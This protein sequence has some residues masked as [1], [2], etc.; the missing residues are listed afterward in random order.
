MAEKFDIGYQKLNIDNCFK[1]HYVVPDYQREYVW[2][3]RQVEQM[4]SDIISAYES[5]SEKPYFMGMTVVYSSPKVFELVDGQQR[6]TTFFITLCVLINIY[7]EI[8]DEA[9]TFKSRIYSPVMDED[10]DE[11]DDFALKLQY[12]ESSECL[13]NI[14]HGSIP[15]EDSRQNLGQSD[16]RLYDAYET[17]FQKLKEEYPTL[18]ELKKF[19][20]YLFKKVEIV[21]IETSDISD[22]L[23][24]F[25]TINQRGVGLNSMDLLKN[26]I[27][28]QVS[29]EDFAKL[30]EQWKA[31]IDKIYQANEKPLRFLRYFITATYD[32]SDETGIIKGILPE[33]RIY[34]WLMDN[35][36]KCGYKK[37]P[38]DFVNSLADGV[39]RFVDYLSP[40]LVEKGNEYLL[41]IPRIA[42][43]SYKSHIVLLMAAN[44]MEMEAFSRFKQIL[45][46]VLYYSTINKIKGNETEKLFAG[47][48]PKI[49]KIRTNDELTTFVTDEIIPQVNSWKE[50]RNYKRNFEMLS[51]NNTQQYRIRYV[52]TRITKY[53]DDTRVGGNNAANIS[54]YYDKKNQI[55]H[56][57]PQK[58]NDLDSYGVSE[59][60]FTDVVNMLGNLTLLEKSFNSSINNASYS[61]KCKVYPGSVFYLTKS[62]PKLEDVGKETASTKMNKKLKSWDNWNKETITDRQEIMYNLSEEIW[63]IENIISSWK[64]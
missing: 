40:N 5:N 32:I 56:I 25:E 46:A 57:M 12:T 28:M 2:E 63:K 14:F 54:S 42:G 30:N 41:N 16:A 26:M 49:R 51:L 20:S 50:N 35:E 34:P 19:G 27:F 24:I 53:V 58:C 45:E 39:K 43:T 44:S 29:R 22:A 61:E 62:L 15:G 17:I 10:G 11:Y 33:D 8:G 18:A 21:Q 23:K 60:E 36:S 52:L 4:L 48:C 59:S 9:S 64:N 31:I 37:N 47:W 6:L 13:K 38:F 55:E 1:N 3:N 7:K